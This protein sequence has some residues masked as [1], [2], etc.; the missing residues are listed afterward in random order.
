MY[1]ATFPSVWRSVR[2]L[3]VVD[4][5]VDDVVQEVFVAVHRRLGQFEGR[6]TLRTWVFG[7]VVRVVN[8]YRRTGRRKGAAHATTSHV[9]DPGDVMDA[10]AD[11]FEL[12]SRAEA[13]RTVRRLLAHLETNKA[14]VFVLAELEGLTVPEIAEATGVNLNTIYSRLRAA[15]KDFERARKHLELE[16]ANR[17]VGPKLGAGTTRASFRARNS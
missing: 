9:D 4:S 12:T 3:G 15:R 17:T 16:Q 8:N 11:P 13:G 14:A 1:A 5:A 2:R 10:G 7:I 6:C